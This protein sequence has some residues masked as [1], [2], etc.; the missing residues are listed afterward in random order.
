MAALSGQLAA[1]RLL[2]D[3]ASMRPFRRAATAGG[4]DGGAEERLVGVDVA[5]A[6]KEGL[7]EQSGLDWGAARVKEGDEAGEGDGEGFAT[8]AGESCRLQVVR[9]RLRCVEGDAAEAAGV[10]EANFAGGCFPRRTAEGEDGV[11]VG[12]EGDLG[13][14]DEEAP[15][16]AEM[17]QEFNGCFIRSHPS[18]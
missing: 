4:T 13:G 18:R 5:D 14:G 6:V 2:A 8:G 17:D 7:V 16:H 12:R 1:Q 11:S 3:L 9:C 10:D 15:R